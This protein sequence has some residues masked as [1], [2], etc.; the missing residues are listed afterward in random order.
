MAQRK[1][2]TVTLRDPRKDPRPGDVVERIMR[3]LKQPRV[4]RVISVVTDDEG[5]VTVRFR[6]TGRTQRIRLDGWQRWA[7]VATVIRRGS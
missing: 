4:R 1:L 7:A 6:Q 3:P 2:A 5:R